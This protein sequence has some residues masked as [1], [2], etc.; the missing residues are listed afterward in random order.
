MIARS[1]KPNQTKLYYRALPPGAQ[2]LTGG[3]LDIVTKEQI[4]QIVNIYIV[5]PAKVPRLHLVLYQL[6]EARCSA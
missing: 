5:N 3:P 1:R 4:H 6:T 2:L